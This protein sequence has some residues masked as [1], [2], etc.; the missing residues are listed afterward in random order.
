[1]PPY[2]TITILGSGSWGTSLAWL[3]GAAT[4]D[5]RLWCRSAE[6][7]AEMARARENARYLPGLGLPASV[8]ATAD[9]ARALEGA[10]LVVV[11]VPTQAVRELL[12][13][14]RPSLPP[15]AGVLIA[16]KGLEQGSGKRLSQVTCEELGEPCAPRV[17]VLSGPNLAGEVIRR[18]PTAT[19]I[20]AADPELARGL[21]QAFGTSFFRVY[22]N[23][24]LV[25]V[26]LGGALKNPI[27]IAAGISDGMG[28]GDN[29]K[30]ALLTRGLAEMTRLGVAA[31]ARAET[32][33]GLSGLGDLMA[34]AHSPLSRNYRLGRALGQGMTLAEAL[35]DVRQTAEGVPTAEAA[36]R[37]ARQS[38]VE[39]PIME[40]LR[41]VLYEGLPAAQAVAGLMARPYRDED[42]RDG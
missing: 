20:S 40:A 38:G 28:F 29:T 41:G 17:A 31:G 5:V 32:F 39:A 23:R 37:L 6:Q 22:T 10:S 34:T 24:D 16:A 19:V 30:A 3:L 21:Q 13:E 36:C 8:T 1:M 12:R 9:A 27:A 11:A 14:L 26:E 15:A 25:G 4:P 18:V 35:A 33:S 42:A 7:A 2:P